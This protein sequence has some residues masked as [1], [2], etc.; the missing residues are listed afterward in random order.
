[1]LQ[2]LT[3]HQVSTY[4]RE[5]AQQFQLLALIRAISFPRTFGLFCPI[6]MI[7]E[8]ETRPAPWR[9]HNERT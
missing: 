9:K 1:M 3:A 6:V 2:S 4:Q 5:F 7:G 8:P